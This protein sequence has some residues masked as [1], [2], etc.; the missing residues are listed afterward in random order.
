MM[1]FC[2]YCKTYNLEEIYD[3]EGH[4]RSRCHYCE[5]AEDAYED[6]K[7]RDSAAITLGNLGPAPR[8]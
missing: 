5:A 4:D 2:S 1:G 3:C 6:W 8:P 7:M